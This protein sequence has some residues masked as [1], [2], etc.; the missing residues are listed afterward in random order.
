MKPKLV[1]NLSIPELKKICNFLKGVAKA[2]G[3]MILAAD[4]SVDGSE[5]KNNT[6]DRVTATDKAVEAMIHAELTANYPDF[7]FLGE[8]SFKA[9]QK[10]SKKPT[11]VVDPIDGTLNFCHGFPN[12]AVSL[13]LTIRRKP[14]VGVVY[15][16]FRGDLFYA[17]QGCGA[18]LQKADGSKKK[19]GLNPRPISSL[20]D[21]LVAVEWGNQRTGP[22]WQLRTRMA[23]D[24]MTAKKDG[25]RM[26]HSLRSSGSAALDFCYV[27]AGWIDVFW[28]GGCWVWDVA[29]GW[30]ILLE[31]GGLVVSANP[32]DWEPGVEGRLYMGIAAAERQQQESIVEEVWAMMGEGKFVF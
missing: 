31:A 4:P 9:G 7:D 17:T 14:V 25:G 28:E 21:C 30:I 15:N 29:A 1:D 11:F 16:P 5:E 8:E 6:S 19:L 24:F 2:A 12:A 22:N 18:V 32:G 26:C 20:N 27:A 3:K 13:A 23:M 10:L